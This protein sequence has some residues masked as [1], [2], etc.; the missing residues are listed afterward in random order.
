M[1]CLCDFE[2]LFCMSGI[3]M[4]AT[5]YVAFLWS[6]NEGFD[7]MESFFIGL[8]SAA[9]NFSS[10]ALLFVGTCFSTESNSFDQNRRV[11]S[12]SFRKKLGKNKEIENLHKNN[13]GI[14]ACKQ[15]S[16]QKGSRNPVYLSDYI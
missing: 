3:F 8:S 10:C 6:S 13:Q 4:T 5:C 15:S 9:G 14:I 2:M 11:R 1:K 16:M 7:V 12:I